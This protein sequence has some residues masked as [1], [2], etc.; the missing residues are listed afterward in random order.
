[1]QY[2]SHCFC[3]NEFGQYGSAPEAECN[4]A[5][6]GDDSVMCGGPWRNSV[7]SVRPAGD[8]R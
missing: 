2:Y 8:G 6:R 4:T 5:C 1:V 7:F 3:D